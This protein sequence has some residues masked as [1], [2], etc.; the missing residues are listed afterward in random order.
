[1]I[2][3]PFDMGD[4]FQT[5]E[6]SKRISV[7]LEKPNGEILKDF[8]DCS[9]FQADLPNGFAFAFISQIDCIEFY[10]VAKQKAHVFIYSIGDKQ[11]MTLG[12]GEVKSRMGNETIEHV[13]SFDDSKLR[14]TTYQHHLKAVMSDYENYLQ[15]PGDSLGIKWLNVRNQIDRF[16]FDISNRVFMVAR[17]EGDK[18]VE[19]A[20]A[21]LHS[22]KMGGPENF[23]IEIYG[24]AED[25]ST[26]IQ[27]NICDENNNPPNA[28]T[29]KSLSYSVGFSSDKDINNLRG[30]KLERH[31]DENFIT[32]FFQKENESVA[33]IIQRN[34]DDSDEAYEMFSGI[35]YQA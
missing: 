28:Q 29:F 31:L 18:I 12:L 14:I 26:I 3:A 7:V 11:P 30:C 4:V 10:T 21:N 32:Y 23:V 20:A 19:K 17:I 9:F 8:G 25:K 1:M 15:K 24:V 33:F 13:F 2:E 6:V 35:K 34:G 27:I 5:F 22:L 16:K